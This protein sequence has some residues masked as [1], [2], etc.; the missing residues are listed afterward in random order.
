VLFAPPLTLVAGAIAEDDD[1]DDEPVPDAVLLPVHAAN[2][3]TPEAPPLP[4]PGSE[5]VLLADALPGLPVEDR[6]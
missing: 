6:R 1:D 5:G 4:E 3:T 2:I